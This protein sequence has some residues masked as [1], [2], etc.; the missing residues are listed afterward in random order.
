M[1]ERPGVDMSSG[2]LIRTG[3][4]LDVAVHGEGWLSVL[5]PDGTEAYTRAGHLNVT[6]TGQLITDDGLPV[7]GD[8][9]PIAIPPAEKI[10]IGGDGTITIQGQ[11]Q[12]ANTLTQVER[13]KLVKPD[14]NNLY[15]GND[16]LFHT[17]DGI[18]A[19]ADADVKVVSK[20]LEGSNVNAVGEMV[21]M[22][23]LQ[24]NFEL[25]VKMMDTAKQNSE[26]TAQ[27]LKLA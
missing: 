12:A 26:Q 15:K 22:M 3:R 14:V 19:V 24:R 20:T 10:E 6:A 7:M 11:G 4:E 18:P 8:N 9:G 25:Q 23:T 1:D 5:S 21:K 16:G 2:T 27:L 17:R 13:I